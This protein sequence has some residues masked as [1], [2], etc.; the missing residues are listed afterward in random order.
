MDN[1]NLRE[2]D[3]ALD[4]IYKTYTTARYFGVVDNADTA[5]KNEI[6]ALKK[7]GIDTYVKVMQE[8]VNQYVK[9]INEQ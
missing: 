7:A 5:L 2:I 1:P 4:E 3:L 6:D 8:R 9:E